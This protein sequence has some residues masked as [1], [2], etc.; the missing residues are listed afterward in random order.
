MYTTPT[1]AHALLDSAKKGMGGSHGVDGEEHEDEVEEAGRLGCQAC[2]VIH[3][4]A[5][6]T[7]IMDLDHQQ[8]AL[9]PGPNQTQLKNVKARLSLRYQRCD[10]SSYR[11]RVYILYVKLVET[12]HAAPNQGSQQ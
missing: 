5:S 7:E 9:P 1:A 10:V 6:T 3:L 11:A 12:Y 8:D 4:Q 2:D